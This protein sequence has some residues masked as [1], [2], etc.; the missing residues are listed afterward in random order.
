MV[1]DEYGMGAD[2]IQ[3][4]TNN[5]SYLYARATKSVSLV[6]AAYYADMCCERGREY[7]FASSRNNRLTLRPRLLLERLPSG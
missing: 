1:Y 3:E 7:N 5:F 6:P 2:E 4:G